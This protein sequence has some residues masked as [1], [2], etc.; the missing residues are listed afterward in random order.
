MERRF[1]TTIRRFI[2]A[3]VACA[4]TVLLVCQAAPA[5]AAEPKVEATAQS[6]VVQIEDARFKAMVARD[7]DALGV[8][9][10]PE[11]IYIHANG[12]M[13]TKAEYLKDVAEGRSRYRAIEAA[14]RDVSLSGKLAITHA[15]VRLHVGTDRIIVA[16]TTGVYRQVGGKWQVVVWQSTPI[17]AVAPTPAAPA[18]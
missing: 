15:L 2:A 1:G 8:M 6:P 12:I 14:E 7:V 11:A 18:R 16:R 4:A 13:Q 9:I 17:T 10:A 5:L 3:P